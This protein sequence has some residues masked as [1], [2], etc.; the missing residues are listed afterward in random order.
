MKRIMVRYQV[1]PELVD[2]NVRHVEA[3]FAALDRERPAGLRYATF[4]LGDGVTFV[5]LASIETADD[6][7]P[8]LALEAFQQ[9]ASSVRARCVEPP[10]TSQLDEIGTY[11]LLGG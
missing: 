4:K 5:H 7:N 9:F 3:V 2:E 11:R 10:V 6:A 8:L 1:K